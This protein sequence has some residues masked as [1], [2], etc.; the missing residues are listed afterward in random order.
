MSK[1]QRTGILGRDAEQALQDGGKIIFARIV[2]HDNGSWFVNIIGDWTEGHEVSL[3][4]YDRM[5]VR[6]FKR[7]GTA[8]SAVLDTLNYGGS[9]QIVPVEGKQ[10]ETII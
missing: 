6:L 8:L 1:Y 3:A 9:I 7:L 5:R 10:A 2:Q 4:L